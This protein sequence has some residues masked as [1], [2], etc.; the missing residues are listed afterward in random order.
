VFHSLLPKDGGGFRA[1]CIPYKQKLYQLL[2]LRPSAR[3]KRCRQAKSRRYADCHIRPIFLLFCKA[4]LHFRF[5]I[6]SAKTG[7]CWFD[8]GERLPAKMLCNHDV[9]YN[10]PHERVW[11]RGHFVRMGDNVIFNSLDDPRI[12]LLE[13]DRIDLKS[14]RWMLPISVSHDAAICS[15]P[16][17]QAPKASSNPPFG[18]GG[19]PTGCKDRAL[20]STLY[21]AH[22]AMLSMTV[23]VPCARGMNRGVGREEQPWRFLKGDAWVLALRSSARRKPG[24]ACL[25]PAHWRV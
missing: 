1:A 15:L 5:L 21:V 8:A 24:E 22:P 10:S 2:K 19:S 9:F 4:H 23:G 6:K 12:T 17:P 16:N 20:K 13:R 18:P 7:W 11:Q 3:S 25:A 14:V